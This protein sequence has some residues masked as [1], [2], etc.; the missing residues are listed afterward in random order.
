MKHYQLA[1]NW[2]KIN[3]AHPDDY[4]KYVR[5]AEAGDGVA[6]GEIAE[7]GWNLYIFGTKKKR[8]AAMS[9]ILENKKVKY[10]PHNTHAENMLAISQA[11][12]K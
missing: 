8:N 2:S 12:I 3:E 5:I 6:T 4:W 10:S 1:V 9:T 11:R 7:A